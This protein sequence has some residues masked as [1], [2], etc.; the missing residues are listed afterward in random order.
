MFTNNNVLCCI[1]I[2][3]CPMYENRI[4]ISSLVAELFH[5]FSFVDATTTGGVITTYVRRQWRARKWSVID[6]IGA[7]SERSRVQFRL[8]ATAGRAQRGGRERV[9][10][11]RKSGGGRRGRASNGTGP[12]ERTVGRGGARGWAI[13]VTRRR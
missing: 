2:F 7:S 9:G 3:L 4:I 1:L 13:A 12:A 11:G 6:R 10:C 8:N 5:S